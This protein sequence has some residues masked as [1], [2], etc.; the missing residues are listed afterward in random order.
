MTLE[1][2][3]HQAVQRSVARRHCLK[4]LEAILI[5]DQGSFHGVELPSDPTNTRYQIFLTFDLMAH[6]SGFY[7]PLVL[8]RSMKRARFSP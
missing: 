2:L 6:G 5:L 3:G 8:G 7:L 4:N 1:D